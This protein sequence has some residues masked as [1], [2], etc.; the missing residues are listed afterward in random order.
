MPK[1]D[2]GVVVRDDYE[3]HVWQQFGEIAGSLMGKGLDGEEAAEFALKAVEWDEINPIATARIQ[4]PVVREYCTVIPKY[5][6]VKPVP[7]AGADGNGAAI[8]ARVRQALRRAG[9]GEA[10]IVEFTTEATTA[11]YDDLLA[12]VV[13]WVRTE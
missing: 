5:P 4:W 9:L 10:V 12:T 3:E 7:L 8:I 2:V 1:Y 13:A 11:G 6:E